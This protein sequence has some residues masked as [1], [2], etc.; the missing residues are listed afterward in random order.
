MTKRERGDRSL[1]YHLIAGGIVGGLLVVALAGWA[2]TTDIAGAVIADGVVVVDSV[3]K[4]IQH[5][6]GGV[7]R[8]IKVHND[9][10]VKANDVVVRLDDTQIKANVAIIT[11]SLD[12]LYARRARLEAE[13]SGAA[14]IANAEE[15]LPRA[16]SNPEVARI[17]QGEQKLFKLRQ[18]SREGSKSQLRER[19]SQLREEVK[20]LTEQIEAKSKEIALINEEL[21]GVLELWDKK[22]T[23]QTRVMALKREAARLEGERGQ[24]IA[25]KASTGGKIAEVE[26]QIIQV[27]DDARSKVAEELSDV[28][29]KIAELSER[30]V[31]AEDELRNVDIR[32]PQSGRVHQLAVHSIGR[33]IKPGDTIMLI[34]PNMD[35]LSVDAKVSPG[36]IDQLH[37][38]Q[39]VVL[40][41]SAF[42]QR[43]TPEV[44]GTVKWI[45]AD[46]TTDER[47]NV[48]YYTVHI[49]V[50]TAEL[51]Q[52]ARRDG[53]KIVPGMPAEAFIKT[54]THTALSYFVKPLTDQIM[55]TFRAG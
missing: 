24:L 30:K 13:R 31:A 46:V 12:E 36:D 25:N 44:T 43:T 26:L 9:D 48:S 51:D 20:G 34:V 22:L 45:S 41:F 17:L 7:V 52:L 4:K 37:V 53:L 55:R 3:V 21:K 16:Q 11:K 8:E 33:V 54:E 38:G 27:D 32:A 6:T 39:P 18:T 15:M 1:R 40:R 10:Q 14:S 42:N 5:R 28:R 47:T 29:A 35:V 49:S 50:P 23:P 2:G 19:A